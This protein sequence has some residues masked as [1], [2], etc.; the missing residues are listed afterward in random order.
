MQINVA[1]GLYYIQDKTIWPS[2]LGKSAALKAILRD[3]LSIYSSWRPSG[4]AILFQVPPH[5]EDYLQN[6]LLLRVF[7]PRQPE[8]YILYDL[9][10]FLNESKTN[11]SKCKFNANVLNTY[12]NRETKV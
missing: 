12:E 11:P 5:N 4:K 2:G 6:F 1:L 3:T 8:L 7:E 9:I 10:H